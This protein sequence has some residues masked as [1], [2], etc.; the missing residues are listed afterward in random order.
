MNRLPALLLPALMCVACTRTVR[1]VSARPA[2]IERRNPVA[3]SGVAETMRRQ[4]RN[5]VDAGE[6]DARAREWRRRL[7][8]NPDDLPARLDLARY[9]ASAGFPDLALDHYRIAASRF[10][11]DAE[12]A[13]AL[14][15]SLSK[16]GFAAEARRELDTFLERHPR[17]SAEAWSWSGI[18]ADQASDLA[19]GER[20][21]HAAVEL[22]PN[23]AAL[24]N[25]LGYNLLLQGRADEASAEFRRALEIDPRNAL[26][27]SNLASAVS[28]RPDDAVASWTKVVDPA[29][30]HNNLAVVLMEH[31]DY[32]G[33]RRELERALNLDRSHP[34][35]LRNLKLVG[36]LDGGLS[37]LSAASAASTWRR[38]VRTLGVVLLGEP[39]P[40]SKQPA[41]AAGGN[42]PAS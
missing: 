30:A 23:S 15:R 6:G 2:A 3:L 5:A 40:K 4:V 42:L 18:L 9:Y 8:V 38:F 19:A 36:D 29:S 35:A 7:A 17:A 27:R 10:P 34:A 32:E 33:A 28:A 25:N 22:R 1:D 16:E 14:A 26:A 39:E 24:H 12:V 21:H 13:V 37:S 31:G 41:V 11:A 20:R